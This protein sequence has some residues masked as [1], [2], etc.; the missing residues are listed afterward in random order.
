M[1]GILLFFLAALLGAALAFVHALFLSSIPQKK[2]KT[3]FHFGEGLLFGFWAL[4]FFQFVVTCSDGKHL[5]GL[6]LGVLIGA[7][8]YH[9]IVPPISPA[10]PRALVRATCFISFPFFFL[11]QRVWVVVRFA[12]KIL[13]LSFRWLL[14]P[15][16]NGLW[17]ATLRLRAFLARKDRKDK[18]KD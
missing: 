6:L 3:A 7:V 1:S 12:C 8:L 18:D 11:V 10:V 9:L 5:W 17:N 13:F 16:E 2:R 4:V 15:L 14:W